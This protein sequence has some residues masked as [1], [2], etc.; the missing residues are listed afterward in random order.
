M[1]LHGQVAFRR[2]TRVKVGILWAKRKGKQ[3]VVPRKF[4]SRRHY[5]HKMCLH[6]VLACSGPSFTLGAKKQQ[7]LNRSGNV[8][9]SDEATEL[10][11][12]VSVCCHRCWWSP[13][14]EQD[15]MNVLHVTSFS[16]DNIARLV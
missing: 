11:E 9:V 14:S 13:V 12:E 4:L 6:P 5:Q 10:R 2:Y 3:I 16:F 15:Y 1:A 7:R 8:Q